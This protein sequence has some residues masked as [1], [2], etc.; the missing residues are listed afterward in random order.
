MTTIEVADGERRKI[1]P[2]EVEFIPV[3][4][5]VPSAH[6]L[7][8]H[9]KVGVV[10][11]S[12]DFKL[13]LTPIDGRRTDVARLAALGDEG[14]ALL[15]ADST[16][17]EEPGFTA[18]ERSVGVVLKRIFLERPD[19][20]MIVAC[21]ASHIHRIQQIMDVAV[22]QGRKVALMGRSME[23][24]VKLARKLN[25][26]ARRRRRLRRPG[27]PRAPP[28]GRGLRHLHRQPGR[29]ARRALQAQPR[30][31]ARRRRGRQPTTR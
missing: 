7:A 1:G 20:R 26:P 10:V 27:E 16:N 13:D 28:A 29:A 22:A 12:G 31:G 3:T 11:H 14:V 6:A 25:H 18:S 8:F 24:N 21:F 5:S 9:T 17:A 4:H 23:A 30:R 15:L 19:R 2:F